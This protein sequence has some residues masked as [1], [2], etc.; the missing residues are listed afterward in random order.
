MSDKQQP[1]E[2]D[3]SKFLCILRSQ[4]RPIDPTADAEDNINNLKM[5]DNQC[6]LKYNIKFTRLAAQTGWNNSVLWHCYYSGLAKH[7]KDIMEQLANLQHL[8][9]WRP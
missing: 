1:W 9:L 7:I 2:N 8:T 5:K 3:Y 6:I 4:F